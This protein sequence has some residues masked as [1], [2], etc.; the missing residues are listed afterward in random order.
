M[1]V[2]ADCGKEIK[3]ALLCDG[4]ARTRE[5]RKKTDPEEFEDIRWASR[6]RRKKKCRIVVKDAEHVSE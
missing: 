1:K 2:C 5:S 6:E 3:Y 4:C